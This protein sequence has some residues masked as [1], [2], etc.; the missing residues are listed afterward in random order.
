[1]S[2]YKIIMTGGG[3]AGHVTPNLALVPSL[4]E[5]GFEIKYIGSKDGIEK[6]IIT[7]NNIPYYGISSGKLRRYFD[8]KNFTD[9]FKV[10]KGIHEARKILSKEKPDVIFSKGGFVTVPVVIAASMKKIP[11]I[12]HES[13]ITPGLANKLASPFCDKLCVTFRES[14]QFVKNNKGVLTGSPIRKEILSGSKA[15]GKEICGFKND[16]DIILIMG[17][18]LGSKVI[19]DNIRKNIDNILKDN[20]IIHICGKGNVDESLKKLDG[21]KQFEY[22]SDELKHLMQSADYIISRAGAN[23]IFEF[24]ALKKPTLLI[25]LSKNASRGDQIL[26]AN[27]FKKEGFSLVMQEEELQEKGILEGIKMLKE[28]KQ[29]LV[30]NMNESKLNDG[31]KEIISVI[32]SSITR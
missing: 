28:S 6:E 13:D 22:V 27:S 23:S 2:K 16:K 30:K 29:D 11:V 25:P 21:Y 26:N 4:Q 9:P 18:S 7:S 17:G 12:A 14:L 31:V 3:T 5:E 1:M 8:I 24:L 15:K 32:K 10:I 19:N 20:N